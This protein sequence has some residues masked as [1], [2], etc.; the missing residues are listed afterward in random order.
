MI[1]NL[2]LSQ[3]ELNVINSYVNAKGVDFHTAVCMHFPGIQTDLERVV[4]GPMGRGV[5]KQ[6]HVVLHKDAGLGGKPRVEKIASRG[7]YK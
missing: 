4:G 2:H 5:L 6:Y 7:V 3:E 1:T